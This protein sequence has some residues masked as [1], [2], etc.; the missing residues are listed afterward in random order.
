MSKEF[1]VDI[2]G[3]INDTHNY[4]WRNKKDGKEEKVFV[5]SCARCAKRDK[6]DAILETFLRFQITHKLYVESD[7]FD[8]LYAKYP[9][10]RFNLNNQDLLIR[11]GIIKDY[12]EGGTLRRNNGEKKITDEIG[13]VEY[14]LAQRATL[15]VGFC[16]KKFDYSARDISIPILKEGKMWQLLMK[17]VLIAKDKT[18][19]NEEEW[20]NFKPNPI[21]C[22]FCTD[23]PR[24]LYPGNFIVN[25]NIL[26]LRSFIWVDK[27]K[28]HANRFTNNLIMYNESSKIIELPFLK[29]FCQ[30]NLRLNVL[31]NMAFFTPGKIFTSFIEMIISRL[32]KL[33]TLNNIIEK[34]K[35]LNSR[36]RK[37]RQSSRF[38]S[39][40]RLLS[41]YSE[42]IT[43]LDLVGMYKECK[44]PKNY[45]LV[46]A[47]KKK[48]STRNNIYNQN[49]K[50]KKQ[51]KSSTMNDKKKQN[52]N[53]NS[54]VIVEI[55]PKKT[56]KDKAKERKPQ[57]PLQQQH[58]NNNNNNNSER[59][60][61]DDGRKKTR[62]KKKRKITSNTTTTTK[63]KTAEDCVI[64]II[65][66]PILLKDAEMTRKIVDWFQFPL[67]SYNQQKEVYNIIQA[68]KRGEIDK[69]IS[70]TS[71]LNKDY[72]PNTDE[73]H[74]LIGA[75]SNLDVHRIG[76][77]NRN[78]PSGSFSNIFNVACSSQKVLTKDS[79]TKEPRY[80]TDSERG[81]I[82]L[83]NTADTPKNCGLIVEN[84]LDT[85]ISTRRF[86]AMDPPTKM[87]DILLKLFPDCKKVI[88]EKIKDDDLSLDEQFTYILANQVLYKI[89][90]NT[91]PI[92]LLLDGTRLEYVMRQFGELNYF[93][94]TQY[95]LKIQIPFIELLQHKGNLLWECTSYDRNIYK[96]HNDGLFYSPTEFLS[97]Y[98][99]PP[100]S[101]PNY[102]NN[103]HLFSSPS[104]N[105]NNNDIWVGKNGKNVPNIFGPS[106]RLTPH[107]N[108]CHLPRVGHATYSA[109]NFVGIQTNSL[110]VGELHQKTVTTAFYNAKSYPSEIINL[111]GCYP[112]I[113]V[114][115][116]FN[117]QEDGIVV[118]KGAIDKG[119]FSA[120]HYE[121]ATIKIQ[122]VVDFKTTIRPG[123][124]LRKGVQIGVFF[125]IGE[126][127]NNKKDDKNSHFSKSYSS[128]IAAPTTNNQLQFPITTNNVTHEI[129]SPELKLVGTT[130]EGGTDEAKKNNYLSVIWMGKGNM[131]DVDDPTNDYYF[132]RKRNNHKLK[133]SLAFQ[134]QN[135]NYQ[136]YRCVK[137]LYNK[138]EDDTKVSRLNLFYASL[139]TPSIGDKLQ[140]TTANKGV[141]TE[142]L[143]DQDMPFIINEVKGKKRHLMPDL[144]INPQFM[145]RQTLDNV[146]GTGEKILGGKNSFMNN[147]FSFKMTDS[148]KYL[149]IGD[150]YASGTLI[151]PYSGLPYLTPVTVGCGGKKEERTS[152]NKKYYDYPMHEYFNH[153]DGFIYTIKTNK[154]NIKPHEL[155]TATIYTTR[156]FLVH[157]HKAS[158][159]MQAS[160][161][162]DVTVA[163]FTGTPV[164]G[165]RGGFATGPQE[166]MT[167]VGLGAERLNMEISQFRSEFGVMD[168][169]NNNNNNDYDTDCDDAATINNEKKCFLSPSPTPSI[170][171]SSSSSFFSDKDDNEKRLKK[172]RKKKNNN[173][174]ND[175]VVVVP[176]SKTLKRTLDEIRQYGIE[177]SLKIQKCNTMH[178]KKKF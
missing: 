156:Y 65:N 133:R 137:V 71:N 70:Q 164:K 101:H 175:L 155:T 77:F 75:V 73:L 39:S 72:E 1:V 76:R 36:K 112:K 84:V 161:P 24:D 103:P 11:R 42:G 91:I 87:Y 170:L 17:K 52:N 144:I 41:F 100:H 82:D 53:N 147:C 160:H 4:V 49:N 18:P 138:I 47:N 81:F 174:N 89:P 167:L 31:G 163:D 14:F 139:L 34:L 15:G 13:L 94:M 143:N 108:K 93:R 171:S 50:K 23:Y 117:N 58:N 3:Y 56:K 9:G 69:A 95:A 29:K 107:P 148:I 96:L 21:S 40:S 88:N 146:L 149:I 19:V 152:S 125:L 115:S 26:F 110:S 27:R 122:G 97:F 35:N 63:T 128:T 92:N 132:Y 172:K 177:P 98:H 140:T 80:I 85:I 165:K 16:W 78:A 10:I 157:N 51:K 120:T 142:I 104:F 169:S 32:E 6:N 90:A 166:Q 74:S 7:N 54:N 123:D 59:D 145:K 141:I 127:E 43:V 86:T 126:N 119:M 8:A 33:Q 37:Q 44:K 64:Q 20:K 66:N 162:N 113:L 57:S 153:D 154:D 118:R 131:M 105:N 173:N 48:R 159:M 22:L 2:T 129:Y 178:I 61:D 150:A 45:D 130:S 28:L 62:K 136:Q 99:D 55:V 67:T 38:S 111:P 102:N 124:V 109:K 60:D 158:S 151:N 5:P 12:Y 168:I 106:I 79:K 176:A 134:S 25:Q 135:P 114:A 116:G 121:T 30:H 83:T 68:L 46:I